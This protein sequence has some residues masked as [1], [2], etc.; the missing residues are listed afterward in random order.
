MKV[1]C[2]ISCDKFI[3]KIVTSTVDQ[4][5]YCQHENGLSVVKLTRQA[6]VVWKIQC[7]FI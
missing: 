6:H 4:S 5:R 2:D 1:S 7:R 3:L